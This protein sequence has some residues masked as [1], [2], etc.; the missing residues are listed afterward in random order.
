MFSTWDWYVEN[1]NNPFK[2]D[3]TEATSSFLLVVVGSAVSLYIVD[4]SQLSQNY[5]GE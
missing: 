5:D 3:A 4:P 1:L 2:T